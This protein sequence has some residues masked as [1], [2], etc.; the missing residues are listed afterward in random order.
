MSSEQ[1]NVVRDWWHLKDRIEE[2][3]LKLLK[4]EELEAALCPED[5]GIEEY[6]TC[7]HKRLSEKQYILEAAI[8]LL[9]EGKRQFAPHTT[10]S[11]VDIFLERYDS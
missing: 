11:D 2:L 8:K 1:E 6:I 5:V 10:N 4:W 7:L 3:E 9:K